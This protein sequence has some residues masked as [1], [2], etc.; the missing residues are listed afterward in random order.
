MGI[1]SRH[2]TRR[3]G[4]QASAQIICRSGCCYPQISRVTCNTLLSPI[5]NTQFE[6]YWWGLSVPCCH[7]L[8][9][10]EHLDKQATEVPSLSRRRTS[11]QTTTTTTT[12]SFS[13]TARLASIHPF[14]CIHPP[15]P[16]NMPQHHLATGALPYPDP[17]QTTQPF[18]QVRFRK[19]TVLSSVPPRPK[20]V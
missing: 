10:R 6:C 20:S 14:D 18:S 2:I 8:V 5:S 17:G 3:S 1:R 12:D 9:M 15:Q 19:A 13:P 16:A 7:R 11:N 4:P